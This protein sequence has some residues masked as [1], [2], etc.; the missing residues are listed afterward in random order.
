MRNPPGGVR[1]PSAPGT[2]ETKQDT[3][4]RERI[5]KSATSKGP[6]RGAP[7][8][9]VKRPTESDKLRWA[10]AGPRRFAKSRHGGPHGVQGQKALEVDSKADGETRR[11]PQGG[12]VCHADPAGA[13]PAI[14]RVDLPRPRRSGRRCGHRGRNH[15]RGGP[16]RRGVPRQHPRRR[17]REHD[18]ARAAQSPAQD[19]SAA[20]GSVHGDARRRQCLRHG[21]RLARHDDGARQGRER[22]HRLRHRAQCHPHG[23][24]GLLSH[25]GGAAR[26]HRAVVQ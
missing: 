10:P 7:P 17:L 26:V 9:I 15:R 1:S 21:G 14:H 19:R 22:G 25:D 24:G 20:G 13:A 5:N 2:D 6:A 23:D 8:K 18:Q 16:A 3:S 12:S 11:G 4:H